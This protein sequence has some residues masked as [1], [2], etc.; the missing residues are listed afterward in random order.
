MLVVAMLL[1][2]A[3][4]TLQPPLETRAP[5]STLIPTMPAATPAQVATAD[6]EPAE[7]SGPTPLIKLTAN[8]LFCPSENEQAAK[9]F[10]EASDRKDAG[11]FAQAET[12]YLK[13]IELDPGYCDA[14]DNLGQLLREQNR[15]D[16]AINWYQKSLK[17]LPT[18]RVALQNLAL[19]YNLQGETDKA[20]EQYQTLAEVAPDDP[21]GYYGLGTVYYNLNQFEKA[22]PYFEAAEKLYLQANSPYVVDAQYYLGFS[23]FMLQD[24]GQAKKYF[25]PIY[26]QLAK[27]GGINYALGICSLTSEPIDKE[28]ARKYI[29]KAQELGVDIP[30]DVLDAIDEK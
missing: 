26:D 15:I 14:M 30:T 29:L 25:E 1:F 4:S 18:N 19:A 3:C 5:V 2:L 24:C 21:E 23:H 27:D 17:I 12:L 13:A 20:L 6:L 11:D 7:A 22:I 9:F 28:A 10:D 16:E 8:D